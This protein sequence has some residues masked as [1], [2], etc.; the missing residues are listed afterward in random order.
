MSPVSDDDATIGTIGTRVR[1]LRLWRHMTL[2]EVAGLAGVSAA[3]L[4]MAERGLRSLDRRSMISALATALRVSETELTGGPPHLGADPQQSGPHAA[5]PMLRTAL[6][7]NTLSDPAVDHARPLAEL[8]Q[9]VT[10]TVEPLRRGCDYAAI[11]YVLP[12]VLDELH[13]H[14]ART[15]EEAGRRR[16]LQTLVE[17]CVTASLTAMHLGYPD[18]AHIA[19]LRAE[20]AARVLGEPTELGKAAFLRFHSA[21]QEMESWDRRVVMAERAADALEP[22]AGDPETVS[23]LGLL[24]LSAALA[25]AVLQRGPALEHWL[26]ESA[27]LAARVPDEMAGNWQSFCSTNV[28]IWRLSLAVERGEGGGKIAELAREVDERKITSRS[29][30]AA[31]LVDVGRGLAREPKAKAE[32]VSW[33]RRAEDAG[34][35]YM[36]NCA[37]ARETVAYLLG[38]ATA[39]AGGRELRGMAARMGIPH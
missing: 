26:L 8:A 33:M 32:A 24:T 30:Q 9:I 25:A 17:A 19:A 22:H 14:A 4:S 6:L 5:I 36:R 11:G 3:Y 39:T 31:F 10:S 12:D 28:A 2:A 27:A 15:T 18:L 23:V 35:Q 7:S 16:A 34:P 13:F 29:R 20:D 38:R 37:P 21:P 1:A